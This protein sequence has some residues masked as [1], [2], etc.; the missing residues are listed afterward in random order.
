M[1]W[2]KIIQLENCYVFLWIARVARTK[3][4]LIEIS[5]VR[6]TFTVIVYWL[7]LYWIALSDTPFMVELIIEIHLTNLEI[8]NRQDS[9]SV[10]RYIGRKML[11]FWL[12]MMQVRKF[13]GYIHMYVKKLLCCYEM[14]NEANFRVWEW[15]LAEAMQ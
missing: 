4:T 14:K 10:F 3:L 6:L 11:A 8:W 5:A 12:V 1:L 7:N 15:V 13:L 2:S 9:N